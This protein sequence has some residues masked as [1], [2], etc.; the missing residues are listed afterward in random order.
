MLWEKQHTALHVASGEWLA[1]GRLKDVRR[2]EMRVNP[3]GDFQIGAA[4]MRAK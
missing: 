2:G 3:D 1:H 4:A